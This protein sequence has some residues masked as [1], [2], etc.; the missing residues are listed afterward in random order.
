MFDVMVWCSWF[1]VVEFFSK[2]QTIIIIYQHP[3][4]QYS[5]PEA[6]GSSIEPTW[7]PGAA[8]RG[9][10]GQQ[11]QQRLY[12]NGSWSK[13]TVWAADA[14]IKTSTIAMNRRTKADIYTEDTM[15]PFGT[16]CGCTAR[17]SIGICVLGIWWIGYRARTGGGVPETCIA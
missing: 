17:G 9:Q 11:Q 16:L 4:W 3:R 1:N 12:R 2:I 5:T 7:A 10:Q 13:S 15:S 14:A 8:G 6:G